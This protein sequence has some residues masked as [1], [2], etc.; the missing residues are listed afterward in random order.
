MSEFSFSSTAIKYTRYREIF[1]RKNLADAEKNSKSD[2]KKL[3]TRI[4]IIKSSINRLKEKELSNSPIE[5]LNSHG[6]S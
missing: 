5:Y 1:S 4:I 6:D 2:H 3:N